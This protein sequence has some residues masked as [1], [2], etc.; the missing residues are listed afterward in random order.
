MATPAWGKLYR[1]DGKITSFES[2][3]CT[4]VKPLTYDP[5]SFSII[6]KGHTLE[7]KK[8]LLWKQKLKRRLWQV[9]E[10]W[11]LHY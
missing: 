1:G 5:Q 7:I 9:L 6:N 11:L 10:F 3:Q 4:L 8:Q 2:R